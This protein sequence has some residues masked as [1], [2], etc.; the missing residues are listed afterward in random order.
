MLV[1]KADDYAV[2]GTLRPVI[3]GALRTAWQLR[4]EK[5][6]RTKAKKKRA[7]RLS[8]R[9]YNRP[10]TLDRLPSRE[11]NGCARQDRIVPPLRG[12]T[13]S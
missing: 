4:M 7:S 2:E 5:N 8:S 9:S 10:P 13:A 6:T 11:D 12:R 3:A 1:R